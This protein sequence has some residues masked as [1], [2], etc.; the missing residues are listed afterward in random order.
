[1]IGGRTRLSDL[2]NRGPTL[3]VNRALLL[4]AVFELL[5]TGTGVQRWR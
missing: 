2:I 5:L 4:A 1:M 3:I